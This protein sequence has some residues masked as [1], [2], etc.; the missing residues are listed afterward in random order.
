MLN[1]FADGVGEDLVLRIDVARSAP[2]VARLDVELVGGSAGSSISNAGGGS[3][4]VAEAAAADEAL[5]DRCASTR[6]Q[7]R[8]QRRLLLMPEPPGRLPAALERPV[9]ERAG[10]D[11]RPR[12]HAATGSGRTLCGDV[13][14]AR[15]R[16]DKFTIKLGKPQWFQ[17]VPLPAKNY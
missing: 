15:E 5:P 12:R 2:G 1:L 6:R 10:A 3:R 14:Q 7:W 11:R 13:G 16:Q 8:L 4:K 9:V 17:A